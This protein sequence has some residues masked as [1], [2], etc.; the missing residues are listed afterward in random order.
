[1][2]GNDVYNHKEEDLGDIKEIM[3]DMCSGK[4]AYAVLSFGG[5]LR[6]GRK[7]IRGALN[8]FSVPSRPKSD[9]SQHT[10]R[11]NCKAIPRKVQVNRC[12]RR[13]ITHARPLTSLLNSG[14]F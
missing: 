8:A 14:G 7:I 1:M 12:H 2:I 4:V 10:H 11:R 5:F 9:V 13:I 3:L 6:Y